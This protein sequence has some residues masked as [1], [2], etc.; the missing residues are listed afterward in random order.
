MRVYVDNCCYNRPF[1][2]QSQSKVLIETEAKLLIQSGGFDMT[3]TIT[4]NQ[5]RTECFK[6]G[7]DHRARREPKRSPK[8]I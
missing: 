6:V 3:K 4:D 5:L 7:R 8:M 2:D 1:D